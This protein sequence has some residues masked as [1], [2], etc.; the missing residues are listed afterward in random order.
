METEVA[1]ILVAIGRL[2]AQITDL[3][4]NVADSVSRLSSE[5]ER[6][7]IN[8]HSLR[9]EFH[10]YMLASADKPCKEHA[11]LI[12]VMK[13]KLDLHERVLWIAGGVLIAVEIG[14]KLFWHIK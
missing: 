2:E 5:S 1:Q 8:L 4:K 9:D 6:N 7:R 14:L 3:S 13:A 12:P 11:S 10:K